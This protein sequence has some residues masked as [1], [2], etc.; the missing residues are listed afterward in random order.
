M[1]DVE[2]F[3]DK[4]KRWSQRLLDIAQFLKSIFKNRN[5][6]LFSCGKLFR[7]FFLFPDIDF[8]RNPKTFSCVLL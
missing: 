5:A 7:N 3:H 6:L 4:G 2:V 8:F 1:T